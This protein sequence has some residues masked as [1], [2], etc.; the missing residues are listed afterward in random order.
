VIYYVGPGQVISVEKKSMAIKKLNKR[1]LE[2]DRLLA[3]LKSQ[4]EIARIL[5]L[6]ESHVSRVVHS[7]VFRQ[8][9]AERRKGQVEQILEE[10]QRRLWGPYLQSLA[11]LQAP[12]R[13][14]MKKLKAAETILGVTR[15]RGKS[16]KRYINLHTTKKRG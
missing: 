2:I 14:V 11:D 1:H 15:S 13:S 9:Q 6:S 8:Y 5:G 16:Q 7:D 10:M 12:D 4:R 3:E